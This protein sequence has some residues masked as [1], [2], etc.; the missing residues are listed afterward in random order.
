[1]RL[2]TQPSGCKHPQEMAAR[3]K[4][5]IPLDQ[6]EAAQH[7]VSPRAHLVRRFT[8]RAA[9]AE[10]LPVGPLSADL[11]RAPALI[12]PVVPF[13]QVAVDF[14]CGAQARQFTSAASA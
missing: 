13:H 6:S 7:T 2:K 11:G 3:E 12:F 14:D 1:R 8:S 4:Q 5:Y 9:I 10:Q